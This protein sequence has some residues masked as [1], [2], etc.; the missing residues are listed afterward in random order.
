M[1]LIA[2][3][4]NQKLGDGAKAA[5]YLNALKKR[6]ARSTAAYDAMKLSTATEQDVLD[7]FA[8]EMCGEFY[9]FGLL[10]RHHC[11][12]EQLQKGNIRAYR[13]FDEKKHYLRPISDLF[14]NQIE[15]AD[16]YGTNGY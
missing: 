14:L 9:R 8:R 13:N 2:A 3:E 5:Q 1:Y 12:K 7:E 11:L 16:E 10:K 15:N 6:A 4:A